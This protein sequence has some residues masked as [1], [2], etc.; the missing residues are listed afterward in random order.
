MGDPRGAEPTADVADESA[1][2][3]AACVPP[4]EAASAADP[5]TPAGDVS[6]DSR[7]TRLIPAS[8][9][10]GGGGSASWLPP[11]GPSTPL[12]G[13]PFTIAE[14]GGAGAADDG[15]T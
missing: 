5:A 12:L 3:E 13:P 10:A 9:A 2:S 6:P 8:P 14:A 11:T 7:D 1:G 15:P 4:T